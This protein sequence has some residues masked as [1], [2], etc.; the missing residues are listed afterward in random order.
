[1]TMVPDASS[2]TTR[3]TWSGST[4]S[5][6]M[7]VSSETGSRPPNASSTVRGSVARAVPPPLARLMASAMRR[8]VVKSGLRSARRRWSRPW[9]V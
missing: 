6:S 9:S 8:A 1:M 7:A 2:T 3:A 5:C 4:R